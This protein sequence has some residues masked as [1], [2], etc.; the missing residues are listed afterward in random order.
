M[1]KYLLF[2]L[3]LGLIIVYILGCG[4]GNLGSGQNSGP[5]SVRVSVAYPQ[6]MKSLNLANSDVR[7]TVRMVEYYTIDVYRTSK[8]TTAIAGPD[9][10]NIYQPEIPT[11]RID[12]PE[13]SATIRNVPVGRMT[14]AIKGYSGTKGVNYFGTFE[15]DV[16]A[17]LNNP[18]TI[19]INPWNPEPTPPP[20]PTPT[21]TT[22]PTEYG[23]FSGIVKDMH[24][25]SAV[26]GVKVGI[27]PALSTTTGA[28]G[29]FSI[30][31]VPTGWQIYM[32][33]NPDSSTKVLPLKGEIEIVTA[34]TSITAYVCK[35]TYRASVRDGSKTTQFA[36]ETHSFL[37]N[38]AGLS[39]PEDYSLSSKRT[40]SSD[41]RYVVFA[42]KANLLTGG[43][44]HPYQQIWCHDR[45]EGKT[46]LISKVNETTTTAD[47]D[48][49]Q[50]F[51]STNGRF[52]VF[53]SYS[54]NLS[55]EVELT[56]NFRNVY[57]W[58]RETSMLELVSY[59]LDGSLTKKEGNGHSTWGSVSD[60]G[61]V[62]FASEVDFLR[63]RS[64][65]CKSTCIYP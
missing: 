36:A 61:I 63:S 59:D 46:E 29:V 15:M 51:I 45:Y 44:A 47:G 2:Y 1:K 54:N 55:T 40:I 53:S 26:E 7:S 12:Y 39:L 17:G 11:T 56:N 27:S 65:V 41:G 52:V 21:P 9:S 30:S 18:G 48:C 60:E 64:H 4:G 35:S 16:V 50:P 25:G 33:T 20:S 5:A 37:G 8:I 42:S 58:D 32:I 31:N 24:D 22:T 3:S 23:T 19:T 43:T 62:A 6:D 34:G 28:G 49:D 13:T 57:L 14:F 38:T 10:L